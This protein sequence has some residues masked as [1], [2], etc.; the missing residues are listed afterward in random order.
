[1]TET[2]YLTELSDDLTT[3]EIEQTTD[4]NFKFELPSKDFLENY[5]HYDFSY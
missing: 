1:M 2:Q 3:D 5:G 4:F